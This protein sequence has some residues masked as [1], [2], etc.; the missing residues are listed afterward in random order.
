MIF[1]GSYTFSLKILLRTVPSLESKGSIVIWNISIANVTKHAAA[2]ISGA[3][4]TA[5]IDVIVP[6]DTISPISESHVES[7]VTL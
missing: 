5:I 3:F 4:S 7:P 2:P 6:S 1:K